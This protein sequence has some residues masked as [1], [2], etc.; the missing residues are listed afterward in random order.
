MAKAAPLNSEEYVEIQLRRLSTFITEH[1]RERIS[2]LKID[3]EGSELSILRDVVHCFAVSTRSLSSIIQKRT[4]AKS[5][6]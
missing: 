3:T 1:Q 5:I 6:S 4:G 2:I